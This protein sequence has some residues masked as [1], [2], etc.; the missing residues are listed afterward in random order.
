MNSARTHLTASQSQNKGNAKLRSASSSFSN[1][2]DVPCSGTADP[3][4][5]ATLSQ[6]TS[7]T[8]FD[9]PTFIEEEETV[10]P[11]V[12]HKE[13]DKLD[14]LVADDSQTEDGDLYLSD[15]RILLVGFDAS[16]MRKLVNM[17][18]R[19]GGSRYISFNEKLTHIVIGKPSE[20]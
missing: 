19:G 2:Q 8:F 14:M 16:E 1:L 4:L 6:K 18:R 5:E 3:D 7:S 10:E 20:E 12:Q 11:A 17:V 15:C 13:D 9:A